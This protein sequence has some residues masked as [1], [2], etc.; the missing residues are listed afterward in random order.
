M[1]EKK[2]PKRELEKLTELYNKLVRKT[3]HAFVI[4]KEFEM[5]MDQSDLELFKKCLIQTLKF[6]KPAKHYSKKIMKERIERIKT[7]FEL[8]E[9]INRNSIYYQLLVLMLKLTKLSEENQEQ[10]LIQNTTQIPN[11]RRIIE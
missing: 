11:G 2:F 6:T 9:V 7:P 4:D 8:K 10:E 3:F 5:G 1:K